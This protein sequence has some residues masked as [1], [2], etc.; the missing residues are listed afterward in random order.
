MEGKVPL[1]TDN[2]YKF[3]ALFGLTLFITTIAAFLYL[4]KTTNELLFDAIVVSEELSSKETPSPTD[5]KRKEV[6]EKKIEIA[7]ADKKAFNTALEI[8]AAFSLVAMFIGFSQWHIVIQPKQD[9]LLDLQIEKA[10]RE[11]SPP[12]RKPFRAPGKGK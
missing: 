12:T 11:L 6:L 3:Y 1:P 8:I 5:L 10:E 7:V 4:H 2:I 9:R